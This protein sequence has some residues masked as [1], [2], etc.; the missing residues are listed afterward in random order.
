MSREV[1]LT[2]MQ[3]S[4]EVIESGPVDIIGSEKRRKHKNGRGYTEI[5]RP[6][7]WEILKFDLM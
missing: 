1:G 6:Y 7:S 3:S 2:E 4:S 5:L